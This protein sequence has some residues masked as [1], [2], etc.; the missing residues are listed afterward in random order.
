MGHKAYI[1]LGGNTGNVPQ[2]FAK[3]IGQMGQTLGT[4]LDCSPLYLSRAWGMEGAADFFNQALCLDTMLE[5]ELLMEALLD[6]ERDGGRV[7]VPGK[8]MSRTLDIDILL[9]DQMIINSEHLHL[10]HPRMHLRRFALQPLHDIAPG[11]MH[12]VLRQ[13]I[14]DLLAA[15]SDPMMP[16]KISMRRCQKSKLPDAESTPQS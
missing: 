6:I 8:M 15:C 7:R 16:D 4:V 13:T 5:P 14:G 9:F 11:L 2:A 1:L 10:P 3:A 12:P